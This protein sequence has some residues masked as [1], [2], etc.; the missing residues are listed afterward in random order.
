MTHIDMHPDF[1]AAHF[2]AA[3]TCGLGNMKEP[4][5]IIDQQIVNALKTRREELRT[6][7][8]KSTQ[9]PASKVIVSQ[10]NMIT[11]TLNK[12]DR[13]EALAVEVDQHIEDCK[14]WVLR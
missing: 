14:A 1:C 2:G 6:Q 7:I 9:D 10:M 13:L 8:R 3:C 4:K 11:S 5:M 12:I